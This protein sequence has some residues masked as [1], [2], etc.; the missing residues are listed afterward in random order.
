MSA[1]DSG[2]PLLDMSGRV[3]GINSRITRNLAT[4]MHVPIDVFR[5]SWDRFVAGEVLGGSRTRRRV[6]YLGVRHESHPRGARIVEV[7]PNS[8]AQRAGLRAGDV[9]TVFAGRRVA[10]G[11]RLADLVRRQAPGRK[12]KIEVRRGEERLDLEATLGRTGG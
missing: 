12:V 6:A 2:G 9:I 5:A 11:N 4:N 8:A 3:I 1:G 10:N 7:I